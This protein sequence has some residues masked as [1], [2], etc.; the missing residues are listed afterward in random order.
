V[1]FGFPSPQIEGANKVLPVS[2]FSPPKNAQLTK[3]LFSDSST[4]A[5][6]ASKSDFVDNGSLKGRRELK[7]LEKK[8]KNSTHLVRIN[9]LSP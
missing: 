8:A 3:R 9:V 5:L 6:G 1:A 2:V 7:I 4:V